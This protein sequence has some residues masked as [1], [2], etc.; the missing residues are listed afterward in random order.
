[1]KCT[2]CGAT[3]IRTS[4]R[5]VVLT[6]PGKL[7]PGRVC[8]PCANAGW[9]LVLG[10]DRKVDPRKK[11]RAARERGEM[12]QE[13]LRQARELDAQQALSGSPLD[14]PVKS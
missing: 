7:K 14:W 11:V 9:L 8:T 4:R 5:A 1:M 6:G 3:R 10:D 12:V 13:M 2:A